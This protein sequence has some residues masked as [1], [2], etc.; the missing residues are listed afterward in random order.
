MAP[1]LVSV[2]LA[3]RDAEETIEEAVESVL[4][5]TVRDL[6][7]VVVDDGSRDGT[8]RRLHKVADGRLRVVTNPS[9]LGL[10]GALNVGLDAAEGAYVARMDADDIAL[11]G[12]LETI[13]AHLRSS[14]AARVV[15]SAMIDLDARGR[16]GTV[17]RMPAGARAVRWAALFSSPFF[18]STVVVDRSLLER[19][20]LRYDTS[21][22]ESEDYE[23]WAR[24]LQVAD[25]DNVPEALVLY[26][27]H[28]A[29]ASE[30]RAALQRECQ[31]TVALR[32]I[33][34]LA[35]HMNPG[36]AELAWRAGAGL[37]LDSGTA[38]E[39]ARAL[40]ELAAAFDDRHGGREGHRAAAWSLARAGAP[41]D[42]RPALTREALRLDPELPLVALAR[43]GRRR[44]SNAERT[45]VSA[46]LRSRRNDPVRVTLVVPEPTP[47]RT[48]MLDR[49][50][51]RPELD[52]T[53]LYAG[54]TVQRRTWT[55]EPRHRAVF[56]EG[57]R[58]PGVYRALRHE[59]PISLGV[60]RALASSR[61]EVVVVSGWSTFASQAA[62]AWCRVREVPYILLVESNERDVRPGWRRAVKGAVVP[63]ILRSA[64]E[65]LVVGRLARE[66]MLAR[67]VEPARISL[68]AD[69]IDVARFG[70]EA[71]GLLARRDELRA[72]VGIAPDDVVVLS[73]AR[74]APE[75][76]LDT[77]VRAVAV[78]ADPRL[79]LVLAGSG[80]E[81]GRLEALSDELG[82]RLVVVPEV[83]WERIAE[84]FAIADVFALLSR[85]EP[86]GVVVNEAAACG[87]PLVV[88][89]RVGAA[90]DL[91]EDGRNGAVVP[92]DDPVAAGNVIRAFAADPERRRAAGRASRVLMREWGYEPSIEN[93]IRV[94]RRVAGR[95]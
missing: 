7:L 55:I 71:E 62:V 56:L 72:E 43:L 65:V 79:V 40:G 29:Q 68:F 73:V 8:P 38:S 58:V 82:V 34:T 48:E 1:P 9:P 61:P 94:A 33:A 87:L 20:G 70:D 42:Q 12:W 16:L 13:L 46:W 14:R 31:R 19:H 95:S 85:H 25:G 24:L 18:H 89:D 45:Q 44:A 74:L 83:R 39:A 21:F 69:T 76:G 26:R 60:F 80:A 86:W 93:L 47:F 54:S 90:F 22:G 66:S 17:H 36:R 77:L 49:V 91:V 59:Y 6:E 10:A 15:G 28:E 37:P 35:P 3:A 23:L 78:A 64:A 2:V 11:P 32:Q 53:V 50:A 5:Q 57:H 4:D 51:A 52:L 81:R 67:G 41:R 63:P 92:A 27:K 88:S 84:R 75:K 30:R